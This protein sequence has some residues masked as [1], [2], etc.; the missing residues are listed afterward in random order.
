MECSRPEYWSGQL[1]PSP[2]DLPNPGIEP[3][4]PTSQADSLPAE[5]PGKPLR[6]HCLHLTW[7]LGL[8]LPLPERGGSARTH[9]PSAGRSGWTGC[10]F[11]SGP[12]Q[13]RMALP[14]SLEGSVDS[15]GAMDGG[16]CVQ[17]P[18]RASG[19]VFPAQH[20]PPLCRPR[21]ACLI[22]FGRHRLHPAPA[23]PGTQG[24]ACWLP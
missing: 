5:P 20:P 6:T 8:L 3:G 2:G 18:P 21:A 9:R 10:P 24:E 17:G 23:A 19:S 15:N 11:R 12:V 16:S 7:P 22:L 14:L 13:D 4:S 1:F